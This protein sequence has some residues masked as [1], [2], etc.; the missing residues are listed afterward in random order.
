MNNVVIVGAG[1]VGLACAVTLRRRGVTVTLVDPGLPGEY[2]SF[3]N[4]GCF[5]SSSFIPLG[6]PGA[7]RQAAGWLLNPD[8]P[9]S[10]PW[11]YAHRIAPW[12]W[13]LHRST[14]LDRVAETADALR[15]LV[16]PS[17]AHWQELAYWAGVPELVRHEGYAFLYESV[18][19]FEGDA[20][21]RRLRAER[22]VKMDVLEGPAI[23]EF[24]S[25]IS[26][27]A[28]RMVLLP[29]QGHC[30]NPLR[31]SQALARGLQESGV[32]FVSAAAVELERNGD[33]TVAVRTG[34]GSLKADAVII[35]A[36]VHSR[37]FARQLGHHVLLDA[38]R[39]YHVML[40][41]PSVMPKI[42]LMSG[43]GKFFATP[44]EEGLRIAGTV[45]LGGVGAPFNA[46]RTE[47]LL[48]SGV[49]LLPGLTWPEKTEWM[50]H[51]PSLPDSKPVIGPAK[52]V[53]NVFFAFGHGHVGLTAAPA[54]AQ[55][56]ADLVQGR[57][58]AIDLAP[59]A[60]DRP[61]IQHPRWYPW[62][63]NT[64]RPLAV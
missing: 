51:R 44:M 34:Q 28:T 37:T 47:S 32:E 53:N 11:A 29:E 4:A 21:G 20:L 61:A 41:E 59:Y 26:E 6:L 16:E 42:P 30:P 9:L 12:L 43:E 54:T 2:C 31:L 39:G 7:W 63:G 35:A 17:V 49:R 24:D 60:V 13:R 23:R 15:P 36:G 58:P 57:K 52:N 8:A 27:S 56:I 3:G 5:S 48:N 18:A 55:I 25:A 22:G 40:Q 46:R 64:Q 45:E 33:D 19:A 14:V 62:A 38:E 10:V 50:G 1:I